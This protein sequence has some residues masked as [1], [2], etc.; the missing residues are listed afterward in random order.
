MEGPAGLSAGRGKGRDDV[1]CG[2]DGPFESDS[3]RGVFIGA[4]RR[5]S[6][7]LRLGGAE[8]GRVIVV[9][10]GVG[11]SPVIDASKSE[12]GMKGN[13]EQCR[14]TWSSF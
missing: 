9:G 7:A 13:G 5:S 1:S 6:I 10:D 3:V 2:R 12:I 14:E 11:E 8:A 4:A